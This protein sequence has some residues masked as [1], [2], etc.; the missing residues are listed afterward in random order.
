MWRRVAAATLAAALVACSGGRPGL[1]AAPAT[2]S[3]PRVI[4]GV[5]VA[6]DARGFDD[7]RSFDLRSEGVVYAIEVDAEIEYSFPL[8]HLHAHLRGGEPVVVEVEERADHLVAVSIEDAG[9]R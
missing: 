5:V 8:S 3:A 7:V 6:I 9:A 4:R 2:P 1:G